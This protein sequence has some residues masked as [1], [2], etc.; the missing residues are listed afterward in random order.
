MKLRPRRA[1]TEKQL[2]Q[3]RKRVCDLPG[4]RLSVFED[5]VAVWQNAR[6]ENARVETNV[7]ISKK[8]FNKL[9]DWYNRE[10][11]LRLPK[12]K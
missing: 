7:L 10:Q 2:A 9:I 11:K 3:L 5:Y 8:E 6:L 4:S 12:E 1:R